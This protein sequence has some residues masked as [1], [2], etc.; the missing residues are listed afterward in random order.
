M[1]H[2]FMTQLS[3]IDSYAFDHP[4]A[5]PRW[6]QAIR[7]GFGPGRF[8]LWRRRIR[9]VSGLDEIFGAFGGTFHGRP[10]V[11]ARGGYCNCQLR[12]R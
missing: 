1:T 9:P 5:K 3:K 11:M 12:S 6:R 2:L 8:R 4:V 7:I 10:I